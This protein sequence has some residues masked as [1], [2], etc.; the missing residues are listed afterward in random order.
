MGE[1]GKRS[2]K[3]DEKGKRERC[4]FIGRLGGTKFFSCSS[5]RQPVTKIINFCYRFF[6]LKCNP[7]LKKK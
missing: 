6:M 7:K 1:D 3:R 5:F 4:E 2:G